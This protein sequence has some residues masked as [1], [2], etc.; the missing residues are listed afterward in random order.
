MILIEVARLTAACIR[1]RLS[2]SV[3]EEFG[4]DG[5]KKLD[6]CKHVSNVWRYAELSRQRKEREAYYEA[7]YEGGMLNHKI[8]LYTLFQTLTVTHRLHVCLVSWIVAPM[9][10]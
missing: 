2:S 6:D 8:F 7:Q 5:T 1:V 9:A 3:L 10:N 4:L